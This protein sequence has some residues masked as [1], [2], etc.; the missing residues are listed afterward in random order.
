[1]QTTDSQLTVNLRESL[2]ET[3]TLVSLNRF[4]RK[5]NVELAIRTMSALRAQGTTGA[6]PK[7]CTCGGGAGVGG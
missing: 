1:M 6:V 3:R 2:A 5:K 4:E 7:G